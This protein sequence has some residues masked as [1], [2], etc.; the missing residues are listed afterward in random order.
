MELIFEREELINK[1]NLLT[2][3]LEK[4]TLEIDLLKNIKENLN[5][6]VLEKEVLF[7]VAP[8]I[9]KSSKNNN[10]YFHVGNKIFIECDLAKLKSLIEKRISF[11][12]RK[13]SKIKE[14]LAQLEKRLIEIET[15]LQ[16]LISQQQDMSIPL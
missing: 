2:Q 8:E 9:L 10:F 7:K 6:E 4:E 16:Q 1:L 13:I 14:E 11:K 5:E 15:K 3:Q 12:E